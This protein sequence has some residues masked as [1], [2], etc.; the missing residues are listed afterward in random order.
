MPVALL[1]AHGTAADILT[2]DMQFT[3]LICS[4]DKRGGRRQA[5]LLKIMPESGIRIIQIYSNPR[6]DPT[7]IRQ[8]C[9]TSHFSKTSD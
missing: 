5:I 2:V 6:P 7:G 3:G 4:N 9:G 1:P 8:Y